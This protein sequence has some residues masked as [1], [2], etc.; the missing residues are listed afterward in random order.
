MG[1]ILK[2]RVALVTG[3]SSG[4]GAAAVELFRQEGAKVLVADVQETQLA[5]GFIH[6]DVTQEADIA[7]AVQRVQDDF[8]GLDILFSNAG[9]GGTFA[10]ICDMEVD[11]WEWVMSLN[12]R[13]AMLGIKHAAPVMKARGGGSIINTASI[14]GLRVGISGAAYSVAKAANVQLT[15]MAAAELAPHNIRVNAICPGIIPAGSV[16]GMLGLDGASME[17]LVPEI[18]RIF[19]TAQPLARAGAPPDIA[20]AALFLASDMSSWVTG[21]AVAVDGGMLLKGPDTLDTSRPGNVVEQLFAM[22]DND[23]AEIPQKTG[24]PA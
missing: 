20:N 8:G 2:G 22:R 14:A 17:R 21:Q 11:D 5:D 1:D 3:G 23:L 6:C 13:A 19:G 7:A 15:M 12:L 10:S 4:I 16:G 24:S 9:A 18:A